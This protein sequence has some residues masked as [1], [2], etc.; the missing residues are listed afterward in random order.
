MWS[1]VRELPR[2][3]Q[4]VLGAVLLLGTVTF[5]S[6]DS[7]YG[8]QGPRVDGDGVYYWV[9]L[10]SLVVDHDVDF[11]NDYAQ[12]G[13]PWGY[14]DTARGRPMNPTTVGTAVLWAPFYLPARAGVLLA[15]RLGA[16]VP[17]D[18]TSRVE[19]LAAFYGSFLYGFFCVLLCLALARRHFPELPALVGAV[20]ASVGGLLIF[21]MVVQPSYSHAPAAFAVAAFVERWDATRDRRSLRGWGLLG[22]LGGLA[23]LVRPQLAVLAVLPLADLAR[24]LVLRRSAPGVARGRLLLGAALGT[25]AAALVFAPQMLCWQRIHGSL[26]VLPQGPGFMQWGHSLWAEVLFHPR[27]G[28]LPWMPLAL[29]S[30]VGLFLL[31]RRQPWLG[32]PMVLLL[33]AT[34]YVNGACWDWWA[35]YSFGARRFTEVTVVLA[36]GLAA[37]A[38]ASWRWVQARA[39]AFSAAALLLGVGAL[40]LLNLIMVKSR[41]FDLVDWYRQPELYKVYLDAAGRAAG[42]VNRTVGNPLSWPANLAFGARYRVS[43]G[44][45]DTVAASYFLDGGHPIAH[46]LSEP[47]RRE[48]LLLATPRLEPFLVSGFGETRQ[49]EGRRVVTVRGDEAC[50]LI[51]LLERPDLRLTLT[52]RSPGGVARV[53][54]RWNGRSLGEQPLPPAFGTVSFTAPGTYLRRGVNQLC[55]RLARTPTPSGVPDRLVGKTGVRSAVD[56]AAVSAGLDV[57]DF[58]ELWVGDRRVG[59]NRRGINA[60]AVSPVGEVRGSRHFDLC[61]WPQGGSVFQRWVEALPQGTLVLLAVRTDASRLFGPLALEALRGIGARTDLRGKVR[62]SYAA[63]GVRGAALGTALEVMS[64]KQRVSLTVGAQPSPWGPVLELERL[65][66]EV[67]RRMK[68]D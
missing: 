52:G 19:E 42:A 48:E 17:T 1:W 68:L 58:A 8:Y 44:R 27:A 39:R 67:T 22:V 14:K 53:S 21:Y 25:L 43:P 56:L 65:T 12:W 28:L 20:G 10:R 31:A 7:G 63:I 18:G 57:G 51:P 9:Y 61:H 59:T 47:K 11:R 64:P 5:F 30:V 60:V 66:L 15:A 33:L 55:F 34:A 24:A 46:P 62:T 54:A 13:N 4:L 2:R 38:D 29:P 16:A 36:I 50:L 26:L 37:C 3:S 40:C 45:Y 35:G 32:G 41:R 6:F 23:A 49:A